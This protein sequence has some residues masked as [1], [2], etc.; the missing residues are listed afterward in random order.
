SSAFFC[1]PQAMLA[2][3][4]RERSVPQCIFQCPVDD[5]DQV[6]SILPISRCSSSSDFSEKLKKAFSN[7]LLLPLFTACDVCSS[8]AADAYFTDL[9]PAWQGIF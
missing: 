2:D 8:P 1:V 4:K 5:S 7:Q 9:L 6:A 3:F